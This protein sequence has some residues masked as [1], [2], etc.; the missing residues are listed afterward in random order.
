MSFLLGGRKKRRG[1]APPPQ[2]GNRPSIRFD[3]SGSRG[4]GQQG[5][6]MLQRNTSITQANQATDLQQKYA[7]P[8][9]PQQ[10]SQGV[11]SMEE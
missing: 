3:N 9:T 7:K 6:V 4:G 2:G 5:M 10:Q 11:I 8:V 1:L